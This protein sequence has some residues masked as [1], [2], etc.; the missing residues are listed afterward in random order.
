MRLG[1][2]LLSDILGPAD[3]PFTPKL[4]EARGG[5]GQYVTLTHRWITL[6]KSSATTS[7][8]MS[9]ESSQLT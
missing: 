9:Q 4:R 3:G 2:V 5:A 7:A 8:I 6:T 1:R